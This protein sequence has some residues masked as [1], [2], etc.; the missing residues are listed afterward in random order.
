MASET[1]NKNNLKLNKFYLKVNHKNLT[2]GSK[3]FNIENDN[4]L[5]IIKWVGSINY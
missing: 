1:A 3:R 5:I 4:N 2:N